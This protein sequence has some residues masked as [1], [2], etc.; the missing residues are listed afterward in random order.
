[1]REAARELVTSGEED[2]DVEALNVIQL[3]LSNKVIRE[4]SLTSRLYLKQRLSQLKMSPR[5]SVGDH[6]NPFNQ[7]VVDLANTEVK[8]E[9]DD[10]TLLLL[11]SLLEA[12]ESFVDTILYGRISITLEDVKASLNS[13]ELQKKVMEHHGGNGEGMSR[14]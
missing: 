3:S 8:I 1:M 6:V 11:C 7:I 14:G 2:S 12:Y 5:T 13:K 4:K 9:D 10:Q